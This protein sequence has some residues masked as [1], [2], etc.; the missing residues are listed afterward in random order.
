VFLFLGL[1]ASTASAEVVSIQAVGSLFY[2][3]EQITIYGTVETGSTGLVT[4]VIRDQNDDFVL[5]THSEIR[6]DDSFEKKINVENQFT[7]NGSY[8]AKG[9]IL[10]MTYVETINFD[11]LL[12]GF[13]IHDDSKSYKVIADEMINY[14][15]IAD[16]ANDKLTEP[17][18]LIDNVSRVPFLDSSKDPSHYVERY[19]AEPYYKSWFDR[20]Y[21]G[22][23]IEETV[24]YEGSLDGVKSTIK[25]I[26][27]AKIIQEAQASSIIDTSMD[28]S[29]DFD[30]A[31]IFLVL[32]ALG[33][34]FG[35]VYV[36]K[37]QADNNT[38][39]IRL[40]RNVIRKKILNPILGSSPKEIIQ[41]RLAKGE[42]TLEEYDRLKSK[43]N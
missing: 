30:I 24:G 4:I 19:Y 13:P 6:H 37:R 8:S 1:S 27:D 17:L 29:E 26:M 18:E 3:D 34:L 16:D 22:Q 35:A 40:N 32:G 25:E 39:Q 21:P 5:L 33:I 9:F 28:T 43:L 7:K 41:T 15:F 23:T 2:K 31:Q 20:N 14:D 36:V 10:D 11:V 12:D 38:R 42:I